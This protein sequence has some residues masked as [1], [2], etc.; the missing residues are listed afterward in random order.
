MSKPTK[1][2]KQW[3]GDAFKNSLKAIS[4]ALSTDQYNKFVQDAEALQPE[5][6]EETEEADETE[7]GTETQ[8]EAETGEDPKNA[9][10]AKGAPTSADLQAQV[11]AL[12]A[13]LDVANAALQTEKKAHEGTT[14]KLTEAQNALSAATANY[15]KLRQA[16][17]PMS[18]EDLANKETDNSKA[19]LTKADI[20]AREE[21]K[22]NRSEA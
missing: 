19:G 18:D 6:S 4:E 15:K 16:V 8:E 20:E 12:S 13:R 21:F 22:K 11:T 3:L 9:D 1:S 14:T 17:N 7:T 10:P 2:A 5:E